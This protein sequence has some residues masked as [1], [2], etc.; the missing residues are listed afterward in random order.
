[1]DS[2]PNKNNTYLIVTNEDT[3]SF[4]IKWLLIKAI[5]CLFQAIRSILIL[6]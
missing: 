4:S 5:L 2:S 1:M 3:P 6:L